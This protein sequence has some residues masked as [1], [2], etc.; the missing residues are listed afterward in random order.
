[1]YT[2]RNTNPRVTKRLEAR[3]S[4]KSVTVVDYAIVN[5]K[6]IVRALEHVGATVCGTTE[7]SK[8]ESADRVVLPGVGAFS[9][10]MKELSTHGLDDALK[11]VA[12]AG[13][14]ILGICLG[15]QMLFEVSYEY[16]KYNGLGLIPG[17]V[18]PM[19][20]TIDNVRKRKIPHVGWNELRR[21][22]N[23]T[24]WKNSCLQDMAPERFCYFSHSYMAVPKNNEDALAIVDYQGLEFVAA[25]QRANV[26]GLQF[27]PELSGNVGLE[28]LR[29]FL[30]Q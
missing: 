10:G 2:T 15:M 14:P 13:R 24:S 9:S 19:N 7:Y 28:V 23:R 27:H 17:S 26:T 22:N 21:P 6:N 25:T 3:M 1:M 20:S 5:L 11:N 29:Q 4:M 30:S 8:V 18:L 12:S 16:G